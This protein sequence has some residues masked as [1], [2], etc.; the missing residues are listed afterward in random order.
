MQ[1]T[2]FVIGHRNPDTDSVVSAVGYAELKKATGMAEAR[3]A[4]AGA[5]NPQTEYIFDR[6]GLELPGVHPGP[7]AQGR[8]LRRGPGEDCRGRH[9]ALAGPGRPRGGRGRGPAHRRRGGP[10]PGPPPLRILRQ[11]RHR[12]D[13]PAQEGGRADERA[14]HGPDHQGAGDAGLR[15]GRDL[16]GYH[17]RRGERCRLRARG[18]GRR[19]RREQGAP[20]GR[21]RRCPSAGDRGRGAGPRHHQRLR[22]CARSSRSSPRR[23]ESLSSSRPTTPPAP[24]FSCSIRLPSRPWATRRRRLY[25]GGRGRGKRAGSSRR[26]RAARPRWSTRRAEWSASCAKGTS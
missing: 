24:R 9:P 19:E 16:Q 26:P 1:K 7:R 15:R 4:R 22:R 12:E 18:A 11:E 5:V 21:P 2:V 20:G 3:A 17:D 14:P 10:L 6:F 13:Q 23:G 25:A 8:V